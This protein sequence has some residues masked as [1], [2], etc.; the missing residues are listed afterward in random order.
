MGLASPPLNA[1]AVSLSADAALGDGDSYYSAMSADGRYVVFQS[2]AANLAPGDDNG[3]QDI[4][5]RDRLL[6]TTEL[7]SRGLDGTA[8]NGTSAAPA[9]SADAR[10][11][12]WESNASDAVADDTNGVWDVFVLDTELGTL[13]LL[14]S[15]AG[16]GGR[17][18][19]ASVSGDGA[20]VAFQSDAAL[21]SNDRHPGADIYRYS[22]A[23][24]EIMPYI[25]SARVNT[26]TPPS[27]TLDGRAV[28]FHSSAGD[29]AAEDGDA[30]TDVF[31]LDLATGAIERKQ[32][33]SF[34]SSPQPA[35]GVD[36]YPRHRALR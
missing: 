19:G 36:V 25:E 29:I 21:T 12:A 2:H 23:T 22:V 17:S 30:N 4:F 14:G 31:S 10:I 3:A 6:G 24:D 27:F 11:I 33:D 13:T 16:Q 7:L 9:M 28:L 32:F 1:E 20:Y 8:A 35:F 15:A 34:A 18:G 5:L 26:K